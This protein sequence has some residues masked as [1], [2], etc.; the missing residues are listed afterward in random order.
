M[1]VMLL[2]FFMMVKASQPITA[3]DGLT[4]HS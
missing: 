1:F 4:H 2:T 3:D